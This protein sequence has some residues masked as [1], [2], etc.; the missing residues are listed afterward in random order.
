EALEQFHSPT[1]A[2]GAF[3]GSDIDIRVLRGLGLPGQVLVGTGC[4]AVPEIEAVLAGNA[5]V[6]SYEPASF[7]TSQDAPLFPD[8]PL[9]HVLTGLHN[10]GQ[11]GGIEDVDIDAP[12]AWELETGSR[13]VIVAVVDSGVDY[14]HPDLAANIWTNPGEIAGNGQDDDSNGSIDDVHGYNFVAGN[15]DTFDSLGHGT[16]VAGTIGAVGDN[17]RGVTGVAW[18]VSLLPLKWAEGRTGDLHNAIAAINYAT[19]MRNSGLNVKIINNSWQTSFSSPALYDAVAATRDAEILFV[20][21][22]GNHPRKGRNL[23]QSPSYPASYDLDNM[24]TVAATNLNDQKLHSS[25]YGATSV[26]LAAPGASIFSTYPQH[27]GVGYGFSAGTSMATPH[28]SGAAALLW[29]RMP[30]ATVA[31]VR[32][33]ILEGVDVLPGLKGLVATEGRLNV[34]GAL[35]VDTYAPRVSLEL[36]EDITSGGN[37]AQAI[38]VAYRDNI[39]IKHASLDGNDLRVIAPGSGELLPVTVK[40]TSED[41]DAEN[42]QVVYELAAPGG[43]WTPADNGVYQVMLQQ[44]QVGDVNGVQAVAG[45]LGSFEVDL[46]G[47]AEFIVNSLEDTVDVDVGDGYIRDAAGKITLR[48]AIQETNALAGANTVY[49]P[50]GTYTLTRAGKDEDQAASGDLD[51]RDKLTIIGT[52]QV[53]IDADELDRVFDI[54]DGAALT[55]RG[56]TVTGGK[57]NAAGGGLRNTG[58]TAIVEQV[59][60]TGNQAGSG[61]ALANDGDGIVVVSSST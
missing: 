20:V 39:A 4:A 22:A 57:T 15:G 61:G 41:S 56:V 12:E 13:D 52:G 23:D 30:D 59:T 29:S 37:A 31:E 10:T 33:A 26:D 24:I 49:L 1:E 40:S 55:L 50:A 46:S 42:I 27:L 7:V 16:H 44:E 9:F 14:G 2:V 18:D 25:H 17:D 8:D 38:H 3:T 34:Y 19:M 36:A 11:A 48:A 6:R 43:S 32:S 45:L 60:L 28:V 35:T 54:A 21:A 5:F 53:T 47:A 58:G 51:I